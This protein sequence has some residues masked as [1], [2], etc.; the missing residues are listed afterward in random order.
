MSTKSD[1]MN[2]VIAHE[3]LLKTLEQLDAHERLELGEWMKQHYDGQ[4]DGKEVYRYFRQSWL[5]LIQKEKDK[6]FCSD[7]EQIIQYIN[8]QMQE[9]QEKLTQTDGEAPAQE[10]LCSYDKY[11]DEK[12]TAL[13]YGSAQ[14]V[15]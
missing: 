8:K 10:L 4:V 3:I 5:F 12:M 6:S 13:L 7:F 11:F 9:V 1:R 14:R 15:R 2:Q